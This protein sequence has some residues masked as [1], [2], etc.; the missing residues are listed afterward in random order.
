MVSTQ[1]YEGPEWPLVLIP[2]FIPRW[3]R[4][5]RPELV[6]EFFKFRGLREA[7]S[8]R[9]RIA[10]TTLARGV[11]GLISRVASDLCAGSKSGG[12]LPVV[13]EGLK[14]RR[15]MVGTSESVHGFLHRV[16]LL[17]GSYRC[18]TYYSLGRSRPAI[19]VW[20][21]HRCANKCEEHI[22]SIDGNCSFFS[23]GNA[24]P[25]DGVLTK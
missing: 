24:G 6:T 4:V 17:G 15:V 11:P 1:A 7:L 23:Q 16:F 22:F 8:N 12:A 2:S 21:M 3:I 10:S 20:V 5:A 13:E 25:T 14:L 19:V 9:W 18:C